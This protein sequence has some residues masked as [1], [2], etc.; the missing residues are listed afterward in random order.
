MKVIKWSLILLI[1]FVSLFYVFDFIRYSWFD[2]KR[3][4]VEVAEETI[5]LA[6]L[7][8]YRD[9]GNVI[10]KIKITEETKFTAVGLGSFFIDDK[11]DL[12]HGHKVRVWLSSEADDTAEK[13]IV[14]NILPLSLTKRLKIKFKMFYFKLV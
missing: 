4:V 7:R 10:D 13:I 11:E 6:G 3:Q 14:Y 1:V 8:T 2:M 12:V 5:Y 9:A